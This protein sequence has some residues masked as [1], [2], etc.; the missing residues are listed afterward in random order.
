[1]A[2][3]GFRLNSNQVLHAARGA[4]DARRARRRGGG[5]RAPAPS[6]RRGPSTR[7]S[8]S[9]ATPAGRGCRTSAPARWSARADDPHQRARPPGARH[10]ARGRSRSCSP[11]PSPCG[12]A[13]A[14][15][16]R[17]PTARSPACAASSRWAASSS[18]TT[19]PRK[20][21][22]STRASKR[23]LRRVVPEGLPI[24]IGP[25]NVV[26][27]SFYLIRRAF[28]RVEGPPRLEAVIRG[29]VPQIIYSAH[30]LTGA[31]AR[32]AS[33]THPFQ[34]TPGGEPQR[35][36]AIRLAVNIAMYVLCSTYKDDLVHESFLKRR[37]AGR[38][39][40][41]T[42][43]LSAD[44]GHARGDR[45]P[46]RSPPWGSCSS[47][48][49]SSARTGPRASRRAWRRAARSR[50]LGLLAAVLRPVAIVSKGS[51][52]GPKVVVLADASRSIDLPGLDGTRR[53]SLE[54]A[55]AELGKR[56]ARG[57]ALALQL[58][59]RPG[60]AREPLDEWRRR[61]HRL[62]RRQPVLGSP[63][64]APRWSRSPAPPTSGR[65]PSWCSPTAASIGPGRSRRP[66][67]PARRWGSSRSPCTR[68][69]SPRPHRATP[70]SAACSPRAPR[71]R[72]S[73]SRCASRSAAPAASPAATSRWSR[74]SCAT[75]ASP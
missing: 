27:K 25:E 24:P 75:R 38:A 58:R 35:E 22:S 60:R 72:T 29:G 70:A 16:P 31:L 37:H 51:L 2:R 44:L 19:S 52:V 59:H 66:T 64:S 23:E 20:T 14:T 39:V 45:S 7:A 74:G 54:R 63:T 6:A 30:D 3:R 49:S 43:A 10:R 50:R 21:A 55:L 69:P 9:R 40:I 41:R 71:W 65:R 67:P 33:G 42:L 17:S 73:P 61:P 48:S 12:A 26:F 56:S 68:C 34:V 5:A 46:A 47:G 4:G 18:S 15:C 57:A 53:Q 36:R 62:P 8:S 28:G 1:M 13:R 11:S 32:G